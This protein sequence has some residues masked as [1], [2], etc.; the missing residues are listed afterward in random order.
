MERDQAVDHFPLA[1]A[2]GGHVDF[3]VARDNP[4]LGAPAEIAGDLGAMDHVLAWQAR[5]V[6]AG[7]PNIPTLDHRHA[8]PLRGQ[9]PGK[10]LARCSAAENDQVVFFGVGH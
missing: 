8:L 2:D 10:E 1:V 9:R 7:S 4:E 6:G 3:P 5:D